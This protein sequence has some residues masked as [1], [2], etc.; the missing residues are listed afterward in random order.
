M[1]ENIW[2][3]LEVEAV[4][5]LGGEERAPVLAGHGDH[6]SDEPAGVRPGDAVEVIRQPRVW[7]V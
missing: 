5:V 2:A 4:D 7:P 1:G 3:V 6:G